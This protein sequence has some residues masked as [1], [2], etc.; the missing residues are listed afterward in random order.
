MNTVKVILDR[1]F[2]DCVLLET[3]NSNVTIIPLNKHSMVYLQCLALSSVFSNLDDFLTVNLAFILLTLLNYL[4]SIR[5]IAH[6]VVAIGKEIWV[7]F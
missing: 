7:D 6:T 3:A 2:V 5:T 4:V 1:D